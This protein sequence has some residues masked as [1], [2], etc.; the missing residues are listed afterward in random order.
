[1]GLR[2]QGPD[3]PRVQVVVVPAAHHVHRAHAVLPAPR[4]RHQS[5]RSDGRH[6]LRDQEPAGCRRPR[7]AARRARGRGHRQGCHRARAPAVPE[8][9]GH[10]ARNGQ[11]GAPDVGGP[12]R[13][14]VGAQLARIEEPGLSRAYRH[15]RVGRRAG[16]RA[17]FDRQHGRLQRGAGLDPSP[18]RGRA[19]GPCGSRAFCQESLCGGAGAR[20]RADAVAAHHRRWCDRTA[21]RAAA[22]AGDQPHA[23]RG[24]GAASGLRGH[25]ADR[26]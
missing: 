2:L 22:S 14:R 3:G 26:L 15:P 16:P 25:A 17:A 20:G 7:A 8:Q 6:H 9:K 1:L 11:D 10:R 12:D 19:A 4:E 5:A 18:S 23:G 24:H 21:D 13:G